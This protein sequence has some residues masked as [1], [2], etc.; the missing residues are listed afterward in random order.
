MDEEDDTRLNVHMLAGKGS[1]EIRRLLSDVREV[2]Q[3]RQHSRQRSAADLGRMLAL[4]SPRP[5]PS[6]STAA[7]LAGHQRRGSQATSGASH[8]PRA[9]QQHASRTNSPRSAAGPPSHRSSTSPPRNLTLTTPQGRLHAQL[10]AYSSAAGA[11]ADPYEGGSEDYEDVLLAGVGWRDGHAA[12][13]ELV[14][15]SKERNAARHAQW[16]HSIGL[17]EV[18]LMP[19][20]KPPVGYV[21]RTERCPVTAGLRRLYMSAP[22]VCAAWLRHHG[23]ATS[24]F[25]A[26]A[27]HTLARCQR[28]GTFGTFGTLSTRLYIWIDSPPYRSPFFPTGCTRAHRRC[29]TSCFRRLR[30]RPQPT[31]SP[32]PRRA[33]QESRARASHGSAL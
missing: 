16:R 27:A 7:A 5:L 8:T 32:R 33:R 26:L 28:S 18:A 9:S 10:S 12:Y 25:L 13:E 29:L 19:P 4:A 15:R 11:D 22:F 24:V 17:K 23:D 30:L 2:E 20:P 21:A 3:E 14:R 6:P 1:G 31:R